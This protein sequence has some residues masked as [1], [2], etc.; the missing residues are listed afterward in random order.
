MDGGRVEHREV[1]V[2]GADQHT[3]FGAA[4]NDTVRAQM[5]RLRNDG[6]A[7]GLGLRSQHTAAKFLVDHPMHQ[8]AAGSSGT[9]G[10][11]P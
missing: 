5:A 10:V 6:Q 9:M 2:V 1:A 4:E 11:M 3:D 8:R 7:I